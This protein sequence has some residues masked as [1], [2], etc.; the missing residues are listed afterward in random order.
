MK[1]RIIKQEEEAK[2]DAFVAR[3]PLAS[4][5][6]TSKWG[7]F[8]RKT[9]NRGDY[10][11]IVIEDGK[12]WLGGTMVIRHGMRG[13]MTW[14]YS[15]R[16]PL[17]DYS[18]P[19][20]QEEMNALMTP[21]KEIAKQENSVF[22]RIDPPFIK[23]HDTQK[24]P[25]LKRFMTTHLGFQPENTLIID[26]TKTRKEILDQMK[27]KGRYNIR[28]AEKKGVKIRESDPKDVVQFEDDLTAFH[29]ILHETTMR[30]KFYGHKKAFYKHMLETLYSEAKEDPQAR[31]YLAEYKDKVIAGIIITY[32]KDTA[33]YYYGVSSNDQ[34]NL[35]APYLLQWHAI[36][37]AKKRGLAH[38][39]FLG[40]SPPNVKKHAWMGVTDFKKKFGG[41]CTT[42]L[43][44]QEYSLNT[45]RYIL[46]RIFKAIKG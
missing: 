6:Q 26:L 24:P 42:Y 41:K 3:H 39:D 29:K 38:Y 33:V 10:W 16:G 15:A 30:D 36:Q 19:T 27:Q 14:L 43:P 17:L 7:H 5:H 45:F 23:T 40:I 31:L 9:P 32:Y 28:L 4:I 46:F 12:K 35:M 22:F 37:E 11:I 2:W 1:A 44:P 20:L 34:R 8:Q 25:K 21:I 13:D 18:S